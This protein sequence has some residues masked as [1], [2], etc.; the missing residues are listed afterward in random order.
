MSVHELA[1]L[2]PLAALCLWLTLFL[3]TLLDHFV[4]RGTYGHFLLVL[5]AIERQAGRSEAGATAMAKHMQQARTRYLARYLGNAGSRRG[6]ARLAAEEYVARTDPTTL[7]ARAAAAGP[8]WSR[9]QV[10]AL[11]ALSRTGHPGTLTLL[12]QAIGSRRPVLAYAALDMLDIHGSHDA[13]ELLLRALES[14]VLPASRIA[15]H[16]EHFRTDLT[17]LYVAWLGRGHPKSRYWVAYLLGK[18][19]YSER[20]ASIL[21]ELL[22]DSAADV[23]KIALSALAALQAPRLRTLAVR[24]LDDPVFFVR[25]Q[26]ARVL[27]GFPDPAVVHALALRLADEHE[28]V[29]LAVKRSLVELGAVTLQHL[30]RDAALLDTP[31]RARIT[32]ITNSIRLAQSAGGISG[33]AV[34]RNGTQHVG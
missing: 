32:Q 23:R 29:Q 34:L 6:P 24:M 20:T 14:G 30:P 5:D 18:S 3:F 17:E 9:A 15:T 2:L 25:T 7:L 8:R 27:A 1:V 4:Y 10:V 13:A 16:L 28:A 19:S 12:E 11:Y 31:A 22:S 26:A 21:E 33:A